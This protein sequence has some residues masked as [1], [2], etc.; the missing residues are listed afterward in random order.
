MCSEPPARDAIADCSLDPHCNQSSEQIKFTHLGGTSVLSHFLLLGGTSSILRTF[1]GG[2]SRKKHPVYVY[3]TVAQ[4]ISTCIARNADN[5]IK[6]GMLR[7]C[8]WWPLALGQL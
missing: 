7:Y 2:T 8:H 1:R 6:A 3:D 5:Q 4:K